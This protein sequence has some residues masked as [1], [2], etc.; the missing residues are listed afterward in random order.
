MK[1]ARQR[2]VERSVYDNN[3]FIYNFRIRAGL[4]TSLDSDV[5]RLTPIGKTEL[6]NVMV[7]VSKQ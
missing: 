3:D 7:M 1:N 6:A 4:F 5:V 2:C